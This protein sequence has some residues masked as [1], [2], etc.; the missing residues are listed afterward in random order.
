MPT[1]QVTA[2]NRNLWKTLRVAA[3]DRDTAVALFREFLAGADQQ[4]SVLQG[5]ADLVDDRSGGGSDFVYQFSADQVEEIDDDAATGE[6]EE[7]DW[8]ENPSPPIT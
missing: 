8:G 6:V 2:S 5:P 3:D 7:F 1:F 4:A